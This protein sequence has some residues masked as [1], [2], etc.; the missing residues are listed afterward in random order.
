M[1][2]SLFLGILALVFLAACAA[3]AEQSPAPPLRVGFNEWWG[4]YTLLVAQEK[5]LFEKYGVEV[6]PVYHENYSDYLIALA[7]G[8]IDAAFIGMGD[9]INIHRQ[10]PITVV[11]VSDDGGEDAIIAAPEISSI[12]SL[13]G[14]KVGI[15][16]GT[17]YELL[18]IEMLR[19]AGMSGGDVAIIKVD[20]QDAVKALKSGQVQAV[21]TW[22]PYL[23]RALA[24]GYQILYQDITLP[25]FPDVIAFQR[26]IAEQRPDEI[27][28][29]LR[30]WFQAVEYRLQ[31][32][33][34]TREIAARYLNMSAEQVEPDD[35]LKLF[36]LND[37]KTFL[38]V[39]QANSIYQIANT[40]S[41]Y[42]VTI[43][44]LTDLTDPLEFI[45]PDFLP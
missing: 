29:F 37:N 23:S 43:G 10:Y 33:G 39:H 5:G 8:Q 2:K 3:P 18:V 44:T 9:A 40:T 41:E 13:M 15:T 38:D 32:E 20:P 6:E 11:A 30:A 17:Q 36:T 24:E 45:S 27:K 19:S 16:V 31:R 35:N 42:L 22:E 25:L 34:E 14:K 21:Y 28:A 12:R 4:D 26:P 1:K 7:S